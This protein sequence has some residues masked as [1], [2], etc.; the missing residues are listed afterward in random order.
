MLSAAGIDCGNEPAVVWGD[1]WGVRWFPVSV[2]RPPTRVSPLVR[3]SAAVLAGAVVVQG[4][5]FLFWLIAARRFTPDAVGVI[6]AAGST[7]TLA[8]V[9]A[10]AGLPPYLLR[11][12]PVAGPAAVRTTRRALVWSFVVPFLIAAGIAFVADATA[13]SVLLVALTA[14]GAGFTGVAF[15]GEAVATAGR[16][17]GLVTIRSLIASGGKNVILLLP[18]PLLGLPVGVSA[19][20][21]GWVVAMAVSAVW[22]TW[23]LR[24][25]LAGL[26]ALPAS[27]VPAAVPAAAASHLIAIGQQLPVLALPL[28]TAATLGAT[29]AGLFYVPWFVGTALLTVALLIAG[30]LLTE[31]ARVEQDLPR[32]I[33]RTVRLYLA[34]IAPAALI[35]VVAAGPLL[36]LFNPAYTAGTGLLTLLAV[37]IVPSCVVAITVTVW[38]I[39]HRLRRAVLVTLTSGVT[40]TGPVAVALHAADGFTAAGLAWLLTQTVTAAVCLPSLIHTWRAHPA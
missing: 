5:G 4:F 20:V 13:S 11:V 33:R 17:A 35:L 16:A 12:L 7:M 39:Q 26:A 29:V 22:Q 19:G 10:T 21:I 37:S 23:R 30:V 1:T 40:A 25:P 15:T 28:V 34:I 14:V 31:G 3:S 9:L 27:P 38:R 2:T 6:T 8:A 18:L 32:L 24:G 36:G